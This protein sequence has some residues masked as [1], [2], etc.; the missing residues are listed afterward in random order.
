MVAKGNRAKNANRS[1]A[2][3]I[4]PATEDDRG[5]IDTINRC[6]W[7]SGI[8]TSELLEQRHGLIGG[9]PWTERIT[10][11]IAAH[12]AQPDVTTF[13]AEQDDRIIGY[14]AAQIRQDGPSDV[15]VVSYNAVDPNYRGQGVGTALLEHV[16]RYLKE[17]GARVLE[18]VTLEADM[19]ARHVYER[20]GF[21]ELTCLIYYSK[22]C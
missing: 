18:V 10:D 4:R 17:Q 1:R 19:P 7:S 8:T 13:V 22:D 21:Q 16:M 9:R 12:L 6:A 5:A 3:R 15:G 14:A 20:M 11:D 2:Y